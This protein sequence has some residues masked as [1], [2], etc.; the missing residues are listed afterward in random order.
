MK[1]D[2]IWQMGKLNLLLH[3]HRDQ[4]TSWLYRVS[5]KKV[6]SSIFTRINKM[7]KCSYI[8]F[9]DIVYEMFV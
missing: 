6:Y 2:I 4:L 7:V 5:H 3:F 1:G 8:I 9:W